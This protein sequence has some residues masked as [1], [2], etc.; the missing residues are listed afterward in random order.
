M[1]PLRPRSVL[2]L[3][4]WLALAPATF[5]QAPP[6]A[7][8]VPTFG[9]STEMVYLRFHIERKKGEYVRGV[10]KD[11]L[12][13]LEDG[14]PQAIAVLETPSMQERT[15]PPELTLALDVSSSVMDA[16]LLD[17]K[18]VRD[19]LFASLHAQAR[20][21]LCAF[22]GELQCFTPP[23]RDPEAVLDGFH[24]AV[25]FGLRTRNTGTRLFA[26][27][28]DIARGDRPGQDGGP[29]PPAGTAR[30]KAQRAIVV[31]SDGLENQ[32]GKWGLAAR[33]ARDA[34]VRV[35]TVLL[36]QA[37]QD[38]ARGAFMRGGPPNRAMYDYKKYD[39]GNVAEETGGLSFEPGTLDT[40]TLSDILRKIATE[41]S[42]EN[43]V[44]Y[45]PEGGPTGRKVT[46][47]V[48]LVDKSLG[49]IPDGQRTLVR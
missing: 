28:A 13:V 30:E 47:K 25:D 16:R 29:P 14:R 4:L 10:A 37:F 42:M 1:P 8:E 23:T 18:L 3:A 5:A 44:G 15:V 24:Q 43:V 7:G 20:V 31:F 12:R 49:R 38:T 48:E 2:P 41:I 26:S 35:Y 32:G 45:Q 22:G 46:V 21:G 27:I 17:E 11:Q 39:L 6:P 34:N 9:A 33:T 40:K 19:V 36:S